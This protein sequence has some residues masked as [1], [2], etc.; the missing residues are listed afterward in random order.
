MG[1]KSA[2]VLFA[3]QAEEVE[4]VTTI[5]VLRRA[6]VSDTKKNPLSSIL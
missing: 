4:M 5:D 3:P 2:L 1:M 6:G